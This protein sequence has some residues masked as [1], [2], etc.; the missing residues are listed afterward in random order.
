MRA[1]RLSGGYQS[2][3]T[4]PADET[5]RATAPHFYATFPHFLTIDQNTC[6]TAQSCVLPLWRGFRVSHQHSSEVSRELE[7][8]GS[9]A[10]CLI[11]RNGSAG[12]VASGQPFCSHLTLI[13]P[14]GTAVPFPDD[15]G[16]CSLWVNSFWGR[17]F[18]ERRDSN[19]SLGAF[20]FWAVA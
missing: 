3:R 18:D 1:E 14:S 16:D 4:V 15:C 19:Q 5:A 13:Y 7:V 10:G 12:L 2:R 20:V 11:C 8:A 9:C 6:C 17:L